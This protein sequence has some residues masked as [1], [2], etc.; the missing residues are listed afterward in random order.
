MIAFDRKIYYQNQKITIIKRKTIDWECF[1]ASIMDIELI[2][3]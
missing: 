1:I 3:L 2:F